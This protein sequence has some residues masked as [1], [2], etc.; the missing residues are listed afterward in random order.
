M[1]RSEVEKS[2]SFT[3][4]DSQNV[5]RILQCGLCE[6]SHGNYNWNHGRF[7]HLYGLVDNIAHRIEINYHDSSVWN[8]SSYRSRHDSK[9][10]NNVFKMCHATP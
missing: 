1:R 10:D 7:R 5:E 2:A 4:H 3:D 9:H 8:V 6:P